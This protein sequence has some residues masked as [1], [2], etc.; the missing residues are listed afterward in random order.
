MKNTFNQVKTMLEIMGG[1]AGVNKQQQAGAVS[2]G[3]TNAPNKAGAVTGAGST[4]A[5][6]PLPPQKTSQYSTPAAY[7]ESSDGGDSAYQAYLDAQKALGD[8]APFK[9]SQADWFESVKDKIKQPDEFS[10]DLDKD[11]FYQQYADKHME[12]AR[13]AMADTMGQAAAMTG[14]YGNSYAQSVGQQAYNAQLDKLN[15]IAPDLYQAA[16]ERYK[17]GKEDMYA[18]YDLGASEYTREYGKYLD[19]YSRLLTDLGLAQ[20]NYALSQGGDDD[21]ITWRP[22]GTLDSNENPVYMS[23]DGKNQAFGAGINPYTGEKHPDAEKGTFSNGYQPDNINGTKLKNTGMSTDITGAN[24]PIWEANGKYWLWAGDG[25]VEVDISDMDVR[26][27]PN[28]SN[29][30]KTNSGTGGGPSGK[31]SANYVK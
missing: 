29:K 28:A 21:I 18:Q 23:S 6:P 27:T 1:I 16:L 22:T 17:M 3:A 8:H 14:G 9:F 10:Y 11:A 20:E 2:G 5:K 30:K 12:Q 25:Y 15:D 4:S 26:E 19:E 31:Y 24:Q 7:Y 13:L